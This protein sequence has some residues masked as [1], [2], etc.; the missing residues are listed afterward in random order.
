MTATYFVGLW[1]YLIV[2]TIMTSRVLDA[3]PVYHQQRHYCF[4]RVLFTCYAIT[5]LWPIYLAVHTL[6]KLLSPIVLR[7]LK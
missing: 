6:V 7:Y 5:T 3:S 4:Q 1:A 2:G